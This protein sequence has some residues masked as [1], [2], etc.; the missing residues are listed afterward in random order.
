MP[1]SHSIVN[2]LIIALL[3][4]LLPMVKISCLLYYI[5]CIIFLFVFC[6][7]FS[8]T[9]WLVFE[10]LSI[11]EN[12]IVIILEGDF[13]LTNFPFLFNG[14]KPKGENSIASFFFF[15]FYILMHIYWKSSYVTT[16]YSVVHKSFS[17]TPE[18][19]DFCYLFHFS[20]PTLLNYIIVG[21]PKI[22]KFSFDL[23][24]L[25]GIA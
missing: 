6:N 20:F 5:Y 19:Y 21:W 22:L 9:L 23:L 17:T 24:L 4:F 7:K 25:Y 11:I 12:L 1:L 2:L 3:V 14:G 16:K 13:F 8:G 18:I 15:L 10:W